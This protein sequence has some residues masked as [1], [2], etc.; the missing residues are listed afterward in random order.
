MFQIKIRF[1]IYFYKRDIEKLEVMGTYS[2]S[3]IT[4]GN[5]L[6]TYLSDDE[7]GDG[8]KSESPTVK[9]IREFREHYHSH[10]QV[11]QSKKLS[12]KVSEVRL[13]Q[14]SNRP[15]ACRRTRRKR[16]IP[17]KFTNCEV[18]VPFLIAS[19]VEDDDSDDGMEDVRSDK[20]L[21]AQFERGLLQLLAEQRVQV[22]VENYEDL[23]VENGNGITDEDVDNELVNELVLAPEEELDLQPF[24]DPLVPGAVPWCQGQEEGD[25]WTAIDRLSAWDCFLSPFGALEEVPHQHKHMWGWAWGTVLERFQNATDEENS[26]RALKWFL[27]LSQA[28]L[29]CPSKGG[30]PGR[31]I[32]AKRFNCLAERRW[33]SLVKMWEADMTVV[34][35][36][37]GRQRRE[38]TTEEEEDSMRR[39][40]IEL[41]GKGNISKAVGRIT[42]HGVGDTSDPHIIQQL[43]AKHPPRG[44]EIQ[45]SVVKKRPVE[46]LRGLRTALESLKMKKGS[47]PGAGGC[48]GEFLITLAEVLVP[49]RM[50]L[51]EDFCLQYLQAEL[52]PWFYRVFLT[53]RTV[54][55]FKDSD[56]DSVRPLG[57]RHPL[58]RTLHRLVVK[59]NK[60]ELTEFLEPQQLA[61]SLGGCNKLF[62]SIR[63]L[64]EEREDFICVKLDCKNAFNCC[65][66]ARLLKVYSEEPSLAHL[67][68]HAAATLAAPTALEDGG[69]RWGEGFEGF[70]QGDPEASPEFC[71][72]WQEF[73]VELDTAVSQGGGMA[74][75][76]MDDGYCVG[77]PHLVFPALVT[78]EEKI[79][80]Q[81]GLELQRTKC[82]VFSWMGQIP[83]GVI[84]GFTLAGSTVDGVFTPGFI[85]VGSPIGSDAY[86][87]AKMKVKVE[88][89]RKEVL[90]T[91][92]LLKDEKQA[93]WTCLRSS[94]SHKLEY[95]LAMVHPS[96]MEEA[97]REVD[98]IFW[99]ILEE[100]CCSH[101]PREEGPVRCQCCPQ[102]GVDGFNPGIPGLRCN[103]FQSLI[104]QLPIKLG[105]LGIRSQELL[106]PYAYYGALE[107]SLP[108]FPGGVCPQ[109][110]HLYNEDSSVDTRWDALLSSGCRTGREL[111]FVMGKAKTEATALSNF[112]E[113]DEVPSLHS[114]ELM[115]LGEGRKDGSSRALLVKE[116]ETLRARALDKAVDVFPNQ[117]CR[118]V[119]VRK[120]AD[121][122]SFSFLLSKPGPHSGI[123]S[124]HFSEQVLALLAV[125]SV[126][127]RGRVGE[128]VGKLKVDK[129][130]DN[131]LNATLPGNHFIRGHNIMKN[132]LNNLFKYCGLM[133][134]V[135]PY[136]VF[137]DLIPQQPLNRDQA[138][139]AAQAIIP[140]LR[141]ELPDRGGG[142]KRTYMEVKTISGQKWYHPVQGE[143][144]VAR[145]A[146]AIVREYSTNA[147][148]A[149][150][151]Y[152]GTE[153]G[154]ITRRLAQIGPIE[155]AAFGRLG[156][157]CDQVHKLVTV[158]A[159][160]RVAKQNLAWS[161]G[162]ES[163]KPVLSFETAYIRQRL[164][165]AVV[166]CF[167]HRLSSRMSQVG[168]GAA[169]ATER[170]GQ[171]SREEQ[172]A[173]Q[174]RGAA[175]LLKVTGRDII[176]RGRFWTG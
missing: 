41:L 134:E 136:G 93:L 95:W 59:E 77:P 165:S 127:C 68:C 25:G 159:E 37:G 128:R 16:R 22:D 39:K 97:A 173:K 157:A 35:A 87:K 72:S 148:E 42:S 91:V 20:R 43:T 120:N 78:F 150:I 126:L 116:I 5:S 89:L 14:P 98:S 144:A 30:A 11:V 137:A 55:L 50:Q 70:T 44:Q 110:S 101:L 154:P 12:S 57:I 124:V 58:V 33:G 147:R 24:L 163:E 156:E 171:W 74:R 170:R 135:E 145:R 40:V 140:D 104:T 88:E 8:G 121:K 71:V 1:K 158:M 65:S 62:F 131:I 168:Q 96:Q 139:R 129:W 83:A 6:G 86:V 23:D 100:V 114:S 105:G 112:L 99:N 138:F 36:A 115:G 79:R 56:Q 34:W 176:Q 46:H 123:P 80:D 19:S 149:D 133:S 162:E 47:S 7:S 153:S 64:L 13:S 141:V 166:T 109:L 108:Y 52:P 51:L 10:S 118:P 75:F 29:R 90:K 103:T 172:R 61:L 106:I 2:V 146:L 92:S 15:L 3:D 143:R 174:S 38:R 17:S 169:T 63:M 155:P 76:L 49:D 9:A 119:M 67:A 45:L 82:E 26:T 130:G 107:M 27:F 122:L 94:F 81:C 125:P 21:P 160:A 28:L 151:K 117:N 164:S 161:K 32:I 66:R 111:A 53:T 73:V 167:G 132:T 152:Y 84:P 69:R 175:W 48:R 4:A 85:C 102:H 142:T 54:A 31:G 60:E 113:D 18:E